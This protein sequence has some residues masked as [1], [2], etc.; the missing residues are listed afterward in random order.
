MMYR[1]AAGIS[2]RQ[3]SAM[4][5]AEESR[6]S[7]QSEALLDMIWVIE[8]ERRL[9]YTA[10]VISPHASEKTRCEWNA[11]RGAKALA[12]VRRALAQRGKDSGITQSG[13]R[14]DD[15]IDLLLDTE[16]DIGPV[17]FLHEA[18]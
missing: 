11:R 7:S 5:G 17:P 15:Y 8:Q 1:K 2:C 16:M 10:A 18:L 14:F 3:K 13:R 4:Q 9:N 12:T 6:S